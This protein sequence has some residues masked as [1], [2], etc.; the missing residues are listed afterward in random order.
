MADTGA[1]AAKADNGKAG[2]NHFCSFNIHGSEIL[3]L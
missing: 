2:A 3:C 1:Y